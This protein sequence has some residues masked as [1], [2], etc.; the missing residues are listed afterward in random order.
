M[1]IKVR[2]KLRNLE[3]SQDYANF[4]NDGKESLDNSKYSWEYGYA[5]DEVDEFSESENEIIEL[6][7]KDKN[8]QVHRITFDN[9]VLLNFKLNNGNKGR[10]GV[11]KI[12]LSKRNLSKMEKYDLLRAY[13]YFKQETPFIELVSG[14]FVTE[15][16]LKEKVGL[17][18]KQEI[19]NS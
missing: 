12:L 2:F 3:F 18:Q 16:E 14:V 9:M 15:K 8:G 7:A 10:F 4:H 13:Y 11:S 19:P 6:E 17:I 1:K 5:V